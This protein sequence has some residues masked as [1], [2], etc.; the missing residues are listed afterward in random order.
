MD[1][2]QNRSQ[3]S[4]LIDF[5]RGG[6]I[7][8]M[9]WG[10]CI[11]YC[12]PAGVDF[13][14]NPVFKFIYSF[15]MPLFMLISG[16]LF[17]LSMKRKET[18]L[19]EY[20]GKRIINL[21]QPAVFGG[22]LNYLL[23]LAGKGIVNRSLGTFHVF[24]FWSSA[25]SLWFLW[26]VI[27]ATAA[28]AIAFCTTKC[29]MGRIAIL[30]F[31]MPIAWV[32]PNGTNNIYMF[33]YYVIGAFFA[34]YHDKVSKKLEYG[35]YFCIPVFAIM[36]LFYKKK[37]YIYTTGLYSE[38]YSVFENLMIHLY[39]WGIGLIGSI[40]MIVIFKW[41]FDAMQKHVKR[42]LLLPKVGRKSLQVYI[43]SCSLLSGF[44]PQI[45]KRIYAFAPSIEIFMRENV[46]LYSLVITLMIAI[47]YAVALYWGVKLLERIKIAPIIFGR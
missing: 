2:S 32:L 8:L 43:I 4:Q 12:V 20:A 31:M 16:Y 46:I 5:L 14:E 17:G 33:P 29:F 18:G 40:A 10:H 42:D 38:Q 26:S 24:D 41:I 13:F 25:N 15:H 11:Q 3:R 7:V 1:T 27:A 39:R 36:I 37:H 6:V 44:L 21:I 28:I 47:L 45:I 9:L 35:K 34:Y 22:M 30:L 19:A 23:A